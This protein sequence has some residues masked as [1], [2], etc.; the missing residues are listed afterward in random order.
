M[1]CRG[2]NHLNLHF[3]VE[4]QKS[5]NKC[6]CRKQRQRLQTSPWPSNPCPKWRDVFWNLVQLGKFYC[7]FMPASIGHVWCCP[8]WY[9]GNSW[10]AML[11]KCLPRQTLFSKGLSISH[12]L[13]Q[14]FLT[15]ANLQSTSSERKNF[16]TELM[17]FYQI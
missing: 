3:F 13:H 16:F 11:V 5:L 4:L 7:S 6:V 9:R 2:L 17:N 10:S 14:F 12:L 1:F 8:K 15:K